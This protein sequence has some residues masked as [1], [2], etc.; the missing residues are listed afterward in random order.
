MNQVRSDYK[1]FYNDIKYRTNIFEWYPF[2]KDAKILYVGD[3]SILISYFLQCIQTDLFNLNTINQQF[4]YII[5]DGELDHVE[6]K[7]SVLHDLLNKRNS[8]GQLIILT[9]NK[10]ALRYF[11][12]VKEYE[13]NEFFGHLKKHSNLYSKNQ[14]D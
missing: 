4:D 5:V 7:E 13:S 2:K 1:E 8:E 6:D 12:G 9:N 10:L 14:W 3:S 11:A